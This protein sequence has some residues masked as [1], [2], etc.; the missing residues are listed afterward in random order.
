M[1]KIFQE[2]LSHGLISLKILMLFALISVSVSCAITPDY[3]RRHNKNRE[4]HMISAQLPLVASCIAKRVK[5]TNSYEVIETK[6]AVIL[7]SGK[8]TLRIY[9]LE[10]AVG[11]TMITL[12]E[13]GGVLF[14]KEGRSVIEYCREQLEKVKP[15]PQ[16]PAK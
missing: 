3:Q 15:I 4:T 8:I 11:G 2:C 5:S 6:E 13:G 12:Y 10:D 9:D 14:L 1:N 16:S 7:M